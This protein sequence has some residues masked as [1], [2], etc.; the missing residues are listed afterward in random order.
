MTW[1]CIN[2]VEPED[3]PERED[4][5]RQRILGFIEDYD[6]VW[7]EVVAEIMGATSS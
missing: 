7:G 6:T 4:R 5:Y 3:I 1:L 2:R